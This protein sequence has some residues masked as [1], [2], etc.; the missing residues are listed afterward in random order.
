M[1]GGRVHRGTGRDREGPASLGARVLSLSARLLRRS[2]VVAWLATAAYLVAEVY[3]FERTYPDTA[4]RQQLAAF[5]DSPA[6]RML[7]G[8][9]RAVDTTGGYVVWDGGWVLALGLA[10]WALL[11]VTR[12][13]RA[14]EES[15]R[16]E[17]VLAAPI[18]STTAVATQLLMLAASIGSVGAVVAVT[19]A[20]LGTGTRSSLL[21]GLGLAG[22]AATVGG[23]AAVTA[24]CFAVR[25]QA[26]GVASAVL[27]LFF[28]VRVAA[29]GSDSRGWLRWLTPFG[30]MDELR[31]YA[32][33]RW[34]VLVLLL[35]APVLLGVAAVALR[36]RRDTAAGLLSF[37]ERR[38][39]GWFLGSGL[40]LAWRTTQ[41]VLAGWVAAVAAYAAVLGTLIT[42]VSDFIARDETYRRLLETLG[43]S[44]AQST[45][46]LVAL[47]AGTLGVAFA[48]YACWRV[49]AIRTEESSG[50]A[51]NLLSRPVP[52]WRWL[53]QHA[54]LTVAAA[55]LL[56]VIAGWAMWAGAAVAGADVGLTDAVGSTL[57]TLPV[58]ALFAGLAV[59]VFGLA[60]K[61][62]MGVSV[63]AVV[64]SYVL[65]LLG[66]ALGLPAAVL[67]VSPFHHVAAV[68]FEPIDP[69]AS[70][71]VCFLAV[72]AALLGLVAFQRRDLAGE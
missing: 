19:M 9:P 15:G 61:L 12:L 34:A 60:P 36:R 41:G 16:A 52:R 57:A 8:V 69:V 67:A 37:P 30:W 47:L 31:P 38:P 1:S 68:P 7:Q 49:G 26:G 27:G 32:G 5:A 71:A 23:L 25:R 63:A 20:S 22:L 3:G 51:E 56:V 21:L 24:Q 62:T 42:A 50:R 55:A 43:M 2:T 64:V 53:G 14:E 29:N 28:L 58:V 70:A 35:G 11:A 65:E 4:S 18:R 54:V 6:V 10:I 59:L 44:R 48:L 45:L 40:A 17:L 46:G 66:T 13:L 72:L 39:R 33:D